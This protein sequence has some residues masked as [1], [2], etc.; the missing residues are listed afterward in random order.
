MSPGG[1]KGLFVVEIPPLSQEC[2]FGPSYGII[3]GATSPSWRERLSPTSKHR[4]LSES[5]RSPVTSA[6]SVQAAGRILWLDPSY[7]Q[8]G[9]SVAASGHRF[10]SDAAASLT[11]DGGWERFQRLSGSSTPGEEVMKREQKGRGGG[12]CPQVDSHFAT[13]SQLKK[14]GRNV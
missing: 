3:S 13:L 2:T 9:V 12:F 1:V 6:S 4:V 11:G 14:G 8:S 10:A 5:A 7:K